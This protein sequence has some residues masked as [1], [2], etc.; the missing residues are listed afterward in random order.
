MKLSRFP[1]DCE[2]DPIGPSDNHS[3]FQSECV[4]DV[5]CLGRQKRKWVSELVT[6]GSDITPSVLT[7]TVI[8]RVLFTCHIWWL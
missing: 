6:A 7:R 2:V 5:P 4:D 3:L 8:A 1:G